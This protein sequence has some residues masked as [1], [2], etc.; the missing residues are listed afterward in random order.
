MS[1]IGE[2]LGQKPK[3]KPQNNN[4][5]KSTVFPIV[6]GFIGWFFGM[7]GMITR[8]ISHGTDSVFWV[9]NFPAAILCSVAFIFIIQLQVKR[10]LRN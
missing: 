3:N 4:I 5:T 9:Y 2:S 1:I 8:Y 10:K 6:M 7:L